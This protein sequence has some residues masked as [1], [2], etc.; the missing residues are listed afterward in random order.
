MKKSLSLL[1]LIVLSITVIGC[2][3]TRGGMTDE[4]GRAIGMVLREKFDGK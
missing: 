3:T 4:E 1:F 2:S